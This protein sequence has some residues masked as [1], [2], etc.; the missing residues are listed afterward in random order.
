MLR[1]RPLGT[2]C[3]VG[4]ML[5][6]GLAAA[7][8]ETVPAALPGAR[9]FSG[10]LRATLARELAAQGRDYEPRTRHLRPD[11]SPIYSNRLLLEAS[12]YLRQHA[13]NPVDWYP[14]GD[15]AFETAR[16]LGRPVLV[17]IG[18]STCHWC[19]VM[20]EE[21]FDDPEMARLLNAHFVAVK[22]DRELRPDIDAVYMSAIHA[23]NGRGGWPLNVWVTPDRKPFY[24]GTYF[25][26]RDR[27]G[28]LGLAT[29][30]RR[31]HESWSADPGRVAALSERLAARVRADLEAAAAD[32]TRIAGPDSLR[33]AQATYARRFDDQCR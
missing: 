4:A 26:P 17:S 6:A 31:I 28:C 5:A 10:S 20:E 33:R 14:W 23:M 25:P 12:P 7:A 27:A 24:A 29:V 8:V 13:H 22:V 15:E 18:Y 2:A 9:P 3:L 19:H 32:A 1:M 16:R 21:S 30:L 11:G